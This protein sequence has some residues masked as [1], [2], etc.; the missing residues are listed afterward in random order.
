MNTVV[1]TLLRPGRSWPTPLP[2]EAVIAAPAEEDIPTLAT[3]EAIV[4]GAA[5]DEVVA[6]T[7]EERIV[8][9]VARQCV[10]SKLL[11]VTIS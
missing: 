11:P 2:I 4:A 6:A 1:A 3:I 5:L 8:L 10:S 9:R 7:A